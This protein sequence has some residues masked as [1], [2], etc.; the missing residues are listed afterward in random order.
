MKQTALRWSVY[1]LGLI[2][3]AFGIA[4]SIKTALGTSPISSVA[5]SIS[6][7]WHINLGVMNLLPLPAL[8]GGRLLC[9]L[10][11]MVTRKKIP[12]KIESVIHGIGLLL[13]LGLSIL[14]MFKDIFQLLG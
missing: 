10:I 8:D 14:I 3:L 11:E 6:E 7:I 12:A 1:L 13:L 9:L 4:L 2:S 5:F